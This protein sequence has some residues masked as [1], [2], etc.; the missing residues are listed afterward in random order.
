MV[1]SEFIKGFKVWDME[2]IIGSKIKLQ[3][4]WF[5]TTKEVKAESKGFIRNLFVAV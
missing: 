4:T 5:D 1:A 3:L 2:S